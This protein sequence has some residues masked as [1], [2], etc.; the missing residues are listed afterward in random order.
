MVPRGAQE[1][2]GAGAQYHT[3][4]VCLSDVRRSDLHRLRCGSAGEEHSSIGSSAEAGGTAVD[5]AAHLTCVLAAQR[6]R[7]EA[8]HRG[9]SVSALPEC[10]RYRSAVR[11]KGTNDAHS[12]HGNPSMSATTAIA[13]AMLAL[14]ART[15]YW[16]A[17]CSHRSLVE[18]G[19]QVR[20]YGRERRGIV[21]GEHEGLP[22]ACPSET[23]E[24]SSRPQLQ[25]YAGDARD[26]YIADPI[27]TN[28]CE[29]VSECAAFD[30]LRS[31][32]I[33]PGVSVQEGRFGAVTPR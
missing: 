10:F 8:P 29:H 13:Q 1:A 16:R 12:G 24:Y 5:F 33:L 2:A 19:C 27:P 26:H 21:G 31:G 9:D 28:G 22:V 14:W 20:S 4:A 3:R 32:E 15:A 17:K 30:S 11:S 7:I 18:V 6:V 23:G 25:H